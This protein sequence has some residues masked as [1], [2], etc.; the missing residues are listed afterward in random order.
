MA[1]ILVTHLDLSQI[2]E[3]IYGARV[4]QFLRSLHPTSITPAF[5]AGSLAMTIGGLFR[6]YCSLTLGKFWSFQLSVR[7]EHRLVT[8]GPYSVVR[9]PSYTGFIVQYVG[10]I[11]MYGSQGSWVRE[12]G[13]LQVLFVK[14]L[15]AIYVFVWTVGT[16]VAVRRPPM[17][18]KML[19][20]A[21]GEEW[22]DW[23]KRVKYRL[24]PGI[25]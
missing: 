4:V 15:A 25:Y 9:H 22:E 1:N 5:L 20:R 7:K 6:L 16:G 2:P 17:E 13:V 24:I 10:I 23:A 12:S 3:E 19:Q 21:L 14:V 11:V 18:D 8:S